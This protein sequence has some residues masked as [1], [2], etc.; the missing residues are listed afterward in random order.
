MAKQKKSEPKRRSTIGFNP[1]ERIEALPGKGKSRRPARF[2]DEGV[3]TEIK[4]VLLQ[5]R[6]R[7][8]QDGTI[9]KWIKGLFG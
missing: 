7:K 5:R 6:K 8:A 1:L 9:S 4:E 3:Q 2:K